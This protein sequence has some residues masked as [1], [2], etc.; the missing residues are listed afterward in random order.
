MP[1]ILERNNVIDVYARAAEN[2]WVIPTFCS[3]NLT[4]TEA[5]LSAALEYSHL[6]NRPDIPV[7]IAITNNYSHR[8]Q[9]INYT[10][11]KRWDLGLKLFMADLKIL[12][13]TGS[14]FQ[15]LSVLLHLDHVQW[16]SD[17]DL[18]DWDMGL[19]SMIMYDASS[20]GFE[21]NI[22]KTASFVEKHG[23][24]IVVEGACDE[25]NDASARNEI[26]LTTP[27]AAQ[28]YINQ[29]GVDFIVVNLG[30]EHR[31]SAAELKYHSRLASNISGL[32]GTKLVLHGT[33]SVEN[34]QIKNLF[35]D[36]IA[37][38]NIWTSLERDSSPVL[39]EDMLR[40]SSKII[41]KKKTDLLIKKGLLGKKADMS[42]SP[43]L[44]HFTTHYRQEIVFAK[45]KD[46]ILDYFHL[47]Y[48]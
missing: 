6:I 3:E 30:T 7:T 35:H 39:F 47:W 19:F 1:L 13:G 26:R 17:A 4:T 12:T 25:I 38:V 10:H 44:S 5:I 36:G 42:H 15:N 8:S 11:T 29:T 31:A 2:K 46:I 22:K 21:E 18:L 24:K 34:D 32:I 45:I 43:S 41:G 16:D 14:P 37:K 27:E 48:I 9:S 33:S 23:K 28:M 40:N 20:L